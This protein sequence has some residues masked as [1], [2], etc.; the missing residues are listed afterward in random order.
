ML[1]ALVAMGISHAVLYALAEPTPVQIVDPE[2]LGLQD[3]PAS[4]LDQDTAP[5][6]DAPEQ[7][8]D[9]LEPATSDSDIP[10]EAPAPTPATPETSK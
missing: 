2:T 4:D 3:E 6:D 8:G 10:A 1:L 9:V 7:E 5:V